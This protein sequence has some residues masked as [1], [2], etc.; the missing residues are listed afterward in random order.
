[1][2]NPPE[3]GREKQEVLICAR[4]GDP[5]LSPLAGVGVTIDFYNTM[6]ILIPFEENVKV[7]GI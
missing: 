5:S 7:P 1:M 4:F 3:I 6:M 2:D